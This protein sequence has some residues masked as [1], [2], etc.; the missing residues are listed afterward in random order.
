[1]ESLRSE[2]NNWYEITNIWQ[3]HN[4]YAKTI[5]IRCTLKRLLFLL[6]TDSAFCLFDIFI[7]YL[8]TVSTNHATE[9]KTRYPCV[10]VSLFSHDNDI[11]GRRRRQ[12]IN[13]KNT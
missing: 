12:V 4:S 5:L 6:T 10:P 3:L 11:N 1:M 8:L 13:A 9:S 7:Q 2:D